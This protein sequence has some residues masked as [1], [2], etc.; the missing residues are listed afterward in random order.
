MGEGRRREMLG[1]MPWQNGMRKPGTP[2]TVDMKNA[3][4]L[5]CECGCKYFLP[6]QLAFIIPAL[7]SPNGHELLANQPI[8]ICL[9]C[10]E[11]LLMPS[12]REK[13]E[14]VA[15]VIDKKIG[16]LEKKGGIIQ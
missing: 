13:M 8:L 5:A 12:Q 2:I 6:V 10:K 4:P 11:P 7:L 1:Q 15:E 14:K 3:T 9:D 16:E